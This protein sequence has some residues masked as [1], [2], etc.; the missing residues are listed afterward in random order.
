LVI[1]RHVWPERDRTRQVE[2][3]NTELKAR[4]EA[5]EREAAQLATN[6]QIKAAD[7]Q[8][9]T[10]SLRQKEAELRKIEDNIKVG[11]CHTGTGSSLEDPETVKSVNRD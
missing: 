8:T 5:V 2:A 7:G 10:S 4:L 6:F 3:V 9:L 11:N 1:Y